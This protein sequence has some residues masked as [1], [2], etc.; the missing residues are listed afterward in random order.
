[1]RENRSTYKFQELK[2]LHSK[3]VFVQNRNTKQIPGLQFSVLSRSEILDIWFFS[4]KILFLTTLHRL[5][6]Y[7]PSVVLNWLVPPINSHN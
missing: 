6:G 3:Q 7:I 1:M 5:R 4:W 2:F